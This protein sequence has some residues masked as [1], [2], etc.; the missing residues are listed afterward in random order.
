[1]LA[2]LKPGDQ[3]NLNVMVNSFE[4]KFSERVKN[5]YFLA[6]TCKDSSGEIAIKVFDLAKDKLDELASMLD[7]NKFIHVCGNVEE[8]KGNINAKATEIEFIDEPEDMSYYERCSGIPIVDLKSRLDK[9]ISS[10]ESPHFNQLVNNLIG[11]N[12]KYRTKYEVWPAAK[13]MHHAYRHGLLEHSLEVYKFVESDQNATLAFDE[14]SR[15]NINWDALRTA[16]LIHDLAKTEELD[17]NQG[18]VKYTQTGE[19]IGHLC[20]G[21]MWAY[22]AIQLVPEFPK[23]DTEALLH[24]LLSHHGRQEWGNAVDIK[25]AE[26][27]I[28]HQADHKSATLNKSLKSKTRG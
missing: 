21:A 17:Y 22:H 3:M 18:A 5:N 6:M 16:A 23:E 8:F 1:M 27:E 25:T 10:I 26:A 11:E 28:F 4:V 13:S 7:E 14:C 20:L 12:G 24:I 9:A 15:P 19:L 2:D